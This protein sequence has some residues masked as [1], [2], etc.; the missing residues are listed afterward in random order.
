MIEVGRVCVKIAGRD[1]GHTAVVV[2][3]VDSTYVLVDGNVRRKKCNIR[4]LEPTELKLDI[5]KNASTE[6]V[7]SALKKAEKKIKEKKKGTKE[8]KEKVKPARKRKLKAKPVAEKKEEKKPAKKAEKK[9]EKKEAK[10]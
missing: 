8:R 10:K 2:D 5:K 6:D 9:P 4:H 7:K 3:V 1:A